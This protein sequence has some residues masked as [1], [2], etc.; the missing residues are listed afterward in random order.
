MGDHIIGFFTRGI[1]KSIAI[2][3]E[4]AAGKKGKDSAEQRRAFN[5]GQERRVSGGEDDDPTEQQWALQEVEDE[6]GDPPP[7]EEGATLQFAQN[8]FRNEIPSKQRLPQA[9]LIPQRRPG[10]RKRGFMRAY[11]PVLGTHAGIGQDEF[12][13][14]LGDFDKATESSQI[15]HVINMACFGIGMV[16]NHICLA[17]SIAVGTANTVAE[18]LQVRYRSNGFL[19]KANEEIFKPRGLYAMVMTWA[20]DKPD[21]LVM[22]VDTAD[23]TTTALLKDSTTTSSTKQLLR[24]LRTSSGTTT[25]AQIPECAPLIHPV[26][27][28]ALTSSAVSANGNVLKQNSTIINDYLDRRSRSTF[29]SENP[30]SKITAAMPDQSANTYVNRFANPDHPVNNGSVFALL[31]GG[32]FDPIGYSR[33]SRAEAAAKK[34]GQEPLTETER[35]DALMGRKVRGRVTGTPSKEIPLLGKMLKKDVLYLVVVNLPTDEEVQEVTE[36]LRAAKAAKQ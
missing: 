21:D 29:A 16:P 25:E 31:T 17:V 35:H 15:F 36:R 14:F 3:S 30:K 24:R 33:V 8:E 32:T 7:Y 10:S 23:P 5:Q 4:L 28:V 11:A 6:L 20:P 27:D 13:R 19:D 22:G 2:T 34:Q 1:S 12:L 18:E 26:L 9:V